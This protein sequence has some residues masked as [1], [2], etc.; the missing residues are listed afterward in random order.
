VTLADSWPRL[1]G[2][3]AVSGVFIAM[4]CCVMRVVRAM[5]DE[6]S[7]GLHIV[8]D[9]IVRMV[10]A[11]GLLLAPSPTNSLLLNIMRLCTSAFGRIARAGAGAVAS[12]FTGD[13]NLGAVVGNVAATAFGLAGIGDFLVAIPLLL[14]AVAFLYVLALYLLRVV[15][16]VFALGQLVRQARKHGAGVWMLSQ[17]IEDFVR[18]DLGRTLAATSS[19]KLVLGTEEAVVDDVREVFR[20]SGEEVAAICPSSCGRGVLLAGHQRALVNVLPGPAIMA[21]ADTRRI[22]ERRTAQSSGTR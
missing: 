12:A 18:T 11:T 10:V 7:D 5:F 15:Q 3:F 19:T 13:L 22:G 14:V 20:L 8:V 6:R 17:R 16:L 9:N 2:T 1:Y 21:L 4:T